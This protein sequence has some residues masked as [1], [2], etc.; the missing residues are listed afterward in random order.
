MQGYELYVECPAD[1]DALV[2][3]RFRAL[4]EV[5]PEPL[6]ELVPLRVT[7]RPPWETTLFPC[8]EFIPVVPREG[9]CPETAT[10][11]IAEADVGDLFAKDLRIVTDGSV[12]GTSDSAAAA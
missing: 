5:I 11:T 12:H 10:G 1:P 2:A 9:S 3:K 7:Q 6:V 4:K 8:H